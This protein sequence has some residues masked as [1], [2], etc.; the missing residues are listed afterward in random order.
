MVHKNVNLNKKLIV[1][2][3]F[4]TFYKSSK[5]ILIFQ[6]ILMRVVKFGYLESTNEQIKI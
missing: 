6:I 4:Q 2:K 1:K 3:F 5:T